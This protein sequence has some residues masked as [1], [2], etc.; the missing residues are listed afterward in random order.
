[1]KSF[2]AEIRSEFRG[3]TCIEDDWVGDSLEELERRLNEH[4]ACSPYYAT[5]KAEGNRVY[6]RY[7]EVSSKVIKDVD[8]AP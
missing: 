5:Q 3:D 7:Y 4:L 2:A 6:V 8:L 1:M